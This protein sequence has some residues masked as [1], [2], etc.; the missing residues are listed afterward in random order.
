MIELT[1]PYSFLLRIFSETV[2]YNNLKICDATAPGAAGVSPAFRT[3]CGRHGRHDSAS[4]VYFAGLIELIRLS[5][6][7]PRPKASASW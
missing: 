4:G 5:C 1:E 2:R 7:D 6:Q 3:Y